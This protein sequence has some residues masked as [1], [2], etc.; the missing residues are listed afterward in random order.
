AWAYAIL[1]HQVIPIRLMIRRSVQYLLAKSALRILIA[2]PVIGI[3]FTIIKHRNRTLTELVFRNSI[4][5]YLLTTIAAV[6]IFAFHQRLRNW[7]D[8]KFFREA[9]NQE[10][11]LLQLIEIVKGCNSI[12][13][14]S[15]CVTEQVDQALHPEHVFL[16]YRLAH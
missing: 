10:R 12:G 3:V 9:Y 7:I 2:L 5:F 15:K 1:R 13:E 11:I 4:Y 16:F 6:L 8:R 14:M